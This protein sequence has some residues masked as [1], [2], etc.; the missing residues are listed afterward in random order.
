MNSTTLRRFVWASTLFLMA[1]LPLFVAMGFK[2][3]DWSTSVLGFAFTAV[4]CLFYWW[5]LG[6]FL[7]RYQ[8]RMWRKLVLGYF[9]SLP[10]YF[11]TLELLYPAV[12]ATFRPWANGQF[13]IYLSATPQFYLMVRVLFYLT[14]RLPRWTLGAAMV[15][16]AVGIVGPMY[17]TIAW[18][19]A[20]PEPSESRAA[21]VGARV[22]DTVEGRIQEGNAVY[23]RDGR[24]EE[25]GPTTLHPDWPRIEAHDHYLVPGLIDV[26]THLQSP[27]EVP[28]GFNVRYFFKSMFSDYAPQRQEYLS[29]GITAIRDLGGSAT[30]GFEL[31]SKI[32]RHSLLGPRLF[33]AGRL[34]TSPH[35]HP[36]S[37]IWQASMS[38]QGAILASD[39]TSL[40]D[41]LN[42]NLADKPDAVKFVH[43]TIGRAK[44]EL[45]AELLSAGIRWANEHRLISVVHAETAAEIED[46]VVAGATGVEHAAYLQNVPESLA[47]AVREK[48]PFIDPTFGEYEMD[49]RLN[50]ISDDQR[51]NR[52]EC[53]YKSVHELRNAGG[54]LVIGTDSPMVRYGSGFHGELAHFVRAGF[55]ADEVLAFAT[56]NNAEYLGKSSELGRIAAGYRADLI[57]TVD[58]PLERLDTLRHPVWTML[59][60]QI[61][62]NDKK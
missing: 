34:V 6:F 31:R 33:F 44:E 25:I 15:M 17:L 36:V 26:H 24:I 32:E 3:G 5:P 1:P 28:I 57:L 39:E 60:G 11:I 27:V 49:L 37:T 14:R 52:I 50:K 61:V 53:S 18:N 43:G 23:I 41:G 20:W 2:S 4:L 42:R 12:G 56:I 9:L 40:I 58:N 62:W 7:D 38:Q 22:V 47:K 48:R 21:I 13:P 19:F 29:A 55:R 54:R 16:F 59:D 35:G 45:S 8:G 46:A 30:K 51:M 10:L